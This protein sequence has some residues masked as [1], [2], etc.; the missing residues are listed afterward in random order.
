MSALELSPEHIQVLVSAARDLGI[1]QLVRPDGS[2]RVLALNTEA[3]RAG[4][5]QL[6]WDEQSSPSEIGCPS[7]MAARSELASSWLKE[8]EALV[9]VI[10]WVRSYS[11]Q[12][13]S[14]ARWLG[15]DAQL[16]SAQIVNLLIDRLANFFS[17]KWLPPGNRTTLMS[18]APEGRDSSL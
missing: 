13:S 4:L 14:R 6:L 1:S 5:F 11:Y 9:Q 15:S 12:C 3:G 2:T 17:S 8:P 10:Q 16:L 18:A 7:S